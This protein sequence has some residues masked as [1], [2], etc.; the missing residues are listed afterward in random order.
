MRCRKAEALRADE[1]SATGS[2]LESSLFR[3]ELRPG[4]LPPGR[5]IGSMI[6]YRLPGGRFVEHCRFESA[7]GVIP[8]TTRRVA[9]VDVSVITSIYHGEV[10]LPAFL[11]H[12]AGVSEKLCEMGVGSEFVLILNDASRRERR[13]V[14]RFAS[15]CDDTVELSPHY[16][17]RESIYASWNRGIDAARG[18]ALGIWNVDDIRNAGALAEGVEL[19]HGGHD[20]VYFPFTL[21][22]RERRRGRWAHTGLSFFDHVWLRERDA[23]RDFL[24]GPFF[25]FSRRLVAQAGPFDHRFHIAG[26]WEWQLRA[27]ACVEPQVGRSIGGVFFGDRSSLSWSGGSRRRVE[28]A[29]IASWY[30]LGGSAGDL[31]PEEEELVRCFGAPI[32]GPRTQLAAQSSA[33]AC[34]LR[35]RDCPPVLAVLHATGPWDPGCRPLV[36]KLRNHLA[37][38]SRARRLI[39]AG[40][41]LFKR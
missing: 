8:M 1:A 37:L 41:K 5:R 3:Q 29:V 13:V 19:I 6:H 28:H 7:Q 9:A 31:T 25:V 11:E 18:E 20:L 23:A 33:N 10:H 4:E 26:D 16:V 40:T 36:S 15:A 2:A 34:L 27:A 21:V 12:V 32:P 17:P 35:P 39:S 24:L 30:G 14:E 22:R 38:K